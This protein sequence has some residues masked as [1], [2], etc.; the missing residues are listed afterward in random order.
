MCRHPLYAGH[1]GGQI[2]VSAFWMPPTRAILRRRTCNARGQNPFVAARSS[3]SGNK[4]A[5]RA[6][7][8]LESPAL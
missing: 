8:S 1:V 3:L 4:R 7:L 2:I 6:H 5:V